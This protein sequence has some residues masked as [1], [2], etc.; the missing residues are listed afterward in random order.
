[1]ILRYMYI[2]EYQKLI[3]EADI[4]LGGENL[5]SVEDNRLIIQSKCSDYINIFEDIE[6]VNDVSAIIGKNSAG[7]TTILK[8]I[9]LLFIDTELVSFLCVFEENNVLYC[10]S[11]YI[12]IDDIEIQKDSSVKKRVVKIDKNKFFYK[13]DKY[14]VIYL[15]NIFDKSAT[16]FAHDKLSDISTNNLLREFIRKN[17]IYIKNKNHENREL[18]DD[19]KKSEIGKKVEYFRKLEELGARNSNVEF[20]KIFP[21][22]KFLEIE[23]LW[24]LDEVERLLTE[25]GEVDD[26]L[27]EFM[28]EIY[29]KLIWFG[30]IPEKIDEDTKDTVMKGQFAFVIIYEMFCKLSA[31]FR[32]DIQD[33]IKG[34]V[35]FIN[36]NLNFI[37]FMS[38]L[39]I[40]LDR[41]LKRE[42]IISINTGEKYNK[43]AMIITK[44]TSISELYQNL[45][46]RIK[47]KID[48]IDDYINYNVEEINDIDEILSLEEINNVFNDIFKVQSNALPDLQELQGFEIISRENKEVEDM[49]MRFEEQYLVSS[50]NYELL[51]REE[52]ILIN[53]LDVL[54]L[55]SKYF[56][57]IVE[58]INSHVNLLQIEV[59]E[60]KNVDEKE[61]YIED[62]KEVIEY[63]GKVRELVSLFSKL[64]NS[65]DIVIKENGEYVTL[66][67]DWANDDF[68]NF[69]NYYEKSMIKTLKFEYY[70]NDISTGHRAYLDMFARIS[71]ELGKKINKE[72]KNI[73]LLIDEADIFLHPEVQIKYLNNLL[74]FLQLF[75]NEKKV[76]II[77]TSNS[78]FIISDLPHT[79][80]VYLDNLEINKFNNNNKT[81]GANIHELLANNFFMKDGVVGEFSKSIIKR[82][83]NNINCEINK[84]YT[85]S[86]IQMIGEPIL[87]EKLQFMFDR[88]FLNSQERIQKEIDECE[89]KL[90]FLKDKQRQGN[91]V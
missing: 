75:C 42:K 38:E 88:A 3:H 85:Y 55:V 77:I 32:N 39:N 40:I 5:Y 90:K 59:K 71:Y 56:E 66:K 1:M 12:D 67:T 51:I 83:I 60:I 9:N 64:V 70:H 91:N 72:N 50:V 62:D 19:F 20:S 63:I 21:F 68:K 13:I 84:E 35:T 44:Y 23:I 8:I 74:C 89:K 25:L 81:F 46:Y 82:V 57:S 2:K 29:D 28:K 30:Y 7:K 54:E 76:Q 11:N 78:P 22:P 87:R 31:Y 24:D 80:I 37:D 52:N 4:N 16:F 17:N 79:N 36:Y 53:L 45:N 43:T 33:I 18:I 14:R 73:L 41:V 26:N 34:F 10:Y 69:L 65:S 15:S 47:D 58:F 48:S 61:I 27:K 6:C 49:M 86:V